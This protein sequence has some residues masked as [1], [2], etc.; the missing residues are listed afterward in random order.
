MCDFNHGTCNV[1]KAQVPFYPT[2]LLELSGVRNTTEFVRLVETAQETMNGV[3][4]TLSHRWGAADFLQLKRKNLGAFCD[5]IAIKDL[6]RTFQDAIDVSR[7]LG[8]NYLWID[9]LCIMQDKDDLNDWFREAGLMHKVYSHSYCNLSATGAVDSSHGLYQPRYAHDNHDTKVNLYVRHHNGHIQRSIR[10][11]QA[12][13]YELWDQYVTQAAINQRGW[14]FQ[15]RALSPRVLHFGR[16]QLFWECRESQRYE[17]CPMNDLEA[18]DPLEDGVYHIKSYWENAFAR[19]KYNA[20]PQEYWRAIIEP[21]SATCF[22][23][24]GDKLIALSGIAKKVAS[25]TGDTYVAG[26]WRKHLEEQLLWRLQSGDS[27]EELLPRS[28]HYCAPSWSWA[29]I[30][31]RIAY[32]F[33]VGVPMSMHVE[34]VQLTYATKDSTGRITS[35]WLDLKGN[36]R[37]FRMWRPSHRFGD[38]DNSEVLIGDYHKPFPMKRWPDALESQ[39]L[40][41]KRDND[42][43]SLFCLQ[44]TPDDRLDATFL[45]LQ[46]DPTRKGWF[47][48]VGL[49]KMMIMDPASSGISAELSKALDMKTD[50]NLPSLHYD[51]RLHTIRIF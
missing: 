18:M 47:R 10:T 34:D 15:E 33:W 11:I 46:S 32:D 48:R 28:S 50:P 22:T 8:I 13:H 42:Q 12:S 27:R 21:Y 31:G 37:A 25:I 14:V 40:D 4:T 19:G 43:G 5:A 30:K 7:K 41:F 35:G 36:L 44:A 9:S 29:S 51:G 26:F 20:K 38:F 45:L 6:P 39:L 24:A 3:Y 17:K 2:R 49:G 1:E 16:H 23:N